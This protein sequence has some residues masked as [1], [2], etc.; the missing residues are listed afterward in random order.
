M[1]SD[2]PSGFWETLNV[3]EDNRSLFLP[4]RDVIL[5]NDLRQPLEKRRPQK[6]EEFVYLENVAEKFFSFI[7]ELGVTLCEDSITHIELKQ[8]IPG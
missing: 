2:A 4:V 1:R 5:G 6:P 3:R 8:K 7:S